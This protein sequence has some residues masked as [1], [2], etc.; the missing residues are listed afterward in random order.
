MNEFLLGFSIESDSVSAAVSENGE[1]VMTF[2]LPYRQGSDL[3]HKVDFAVETIKELADEYSPKA[4]G[5]TGSDKNFI[6]LS[7]KGIPIKESSLKDFSEAETTEFI[8]KAKSISGKELKETDKLLFHFINKQKGLVPKD[9]ETFCGL[10]DL[11][12][13]AVAEKEKPVLH[14][15]EIFNYGFF[16]FDKRDFDNKAIIKCQLA[17]IKYPEVSD[18]TDIFGYYKNIPLLCAIGKE[19]AEFLGE[20]E[21]DGVLIELEEDFNKMTARET[22][23]A[24]QNA[25]RIPLFDNENLFIV[26]DTEGTYGF[27][28]LIRFM[29]R[30]AVSFGANAEDLD[31]IINTLAL[32]ASRE[33]KLPKIKF[34]SGKIKITADIST[35]SPDRLCAGFIR[36]EAERLCPFKKAPS[37]IS[38]YGSKVSTSPALIQELSLVFGIKA[39][40]ID[41]S[42][43]AAKGAAY[44]A[45]LNK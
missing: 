36:E 28:E 20:S 37:S 44:F 26:K 45:G 39:N 7:K 29:T 22:E 42:L 13:M 35:L 19:Q 8:E 27:K 18:R 1:T 10:S 3:K 15:S 21:T 38:V 14:T 5:I 43:S 25:K 9:A 23:Q 30:T 41:I 33:K 31:D 11:V 40:I 12:L 32:S 34:D 17:D 16:D 24:P 4:I 2:S 6:Y